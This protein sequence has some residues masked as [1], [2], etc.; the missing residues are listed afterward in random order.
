MNAL[1]LPAT[2]DSSFFSYETMLQESNVLELLIS[3]GTFGTII[4]FGS[5]SLH[6]IC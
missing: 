2:F 3:G 5:I 6:I 1:T 4:W